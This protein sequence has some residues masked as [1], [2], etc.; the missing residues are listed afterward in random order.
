MT[1]STRRKEGIH[2]FTPIIHDSLQP[3]TSWHR[4]ERILSQNDQSNSRDA[5]RR[6]CCGRREHGVWIAGVPP[7]CTLLSSSR[8]ARKDGG[9]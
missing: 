2:H 7:S 8:Q 1:S 5:A 3:G 9:K 4:A 6:Q